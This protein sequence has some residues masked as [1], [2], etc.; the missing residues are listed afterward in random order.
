MRQCTGSYDLACASSVH[1]PV[2][3]SGSIQ[4][5]TTALDAALLSALLALHRLTVDPG[6]L[7]GIIERGLY[8]VD[9][10]FFAGYDVAMN[11]LAQKV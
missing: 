5:N 7:I 6:Y 8:P 3:V 2:D 11:I 4:L 10:D 9:P 1:V